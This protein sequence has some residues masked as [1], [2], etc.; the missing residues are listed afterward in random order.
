M[1]LKSW[2]GAVVTVLMV[3]CGPMEA[4]SVDEGAQVSPLSQEEL[5]K[6]QASIPVPDA[7]MLQ[8]LRA[9]CGTPLEGACVAAG[10]G[11][12]TGWSAVVDCGAIS[13][14]DPDDITCKQRVCNPE[15]PNDC[16]WY[17]RGTQYQA[18]NQYRVC[19]NT[20][21]QSC[22]EYRQTSRFICGCGGN[23]IPF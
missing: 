16:E 1:N 8:S 11:A 23:G 20:L 3:G 10:Y 12:C 15:R 7:E 17:T 14:C 21:G 2:V 5:A 4:A 22:T 18:S 6:L 19:S 9:A 13:A